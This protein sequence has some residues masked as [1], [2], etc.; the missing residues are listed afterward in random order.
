MPIV[1]HRPTAGRAPSDRGS[2][3]PREAS[4]ADRAI[5]CEGGTGRIRG[6]I[7]AVLVAALTL[8][9]PVAPA[10][11]DGA[12]WTPIAAAVNSGWQSVAYG[13]GVWVAVAKRSFG[14]PQ[15]MRST[16]GGLSWTAVAATEENEWRSVAYGNEVWV[17]VS[18]SGTN[19]VMR[20]TDNGVTWNNTGVTGVGAN[21]WFS[22]AYGA[23]VWVAVAQSTNQLM[24]STD[25]G[26]TWTTIAVA[27]S[28]DWR[29]VAYGNGTWVAIGSDVAGGVRQVMRSENAGLTWAGVDATE[30]SGW[31]SV[32]YGGGVWVA[33]A[34]STGTDRVMRSTDEGRNWARISVTQEAWQS[35]A[36]G[37]GVWVAVASGGTNRVMRSTDGGQTWTDVA[38]AEANTWF[39]VAYGNGAWIAV[40]QS[41]SGT[42]RVMRSVDPLPV[43]QPV[44]PSVSC[45]PEV[46]VAG[47]LVT[48]SVTGGDAGIDIL[49]RAA[50]GPVFAEVGVTLDDS[51]SGEFSF[52]VPAGA[53]GEEL[54]VELVEWIA[55][56]SLGVVGGPVP[57]SVPSG[58]GPA[59]VWPL[60]LVALVVFGLPGRG[61]R[62]EV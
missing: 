3:E 57:T 34:Q 38:A 1:P 41:G 2:S 56:V 30:A 52:T 27:D 20:S 51:G 4:D 10:A 47:G 44:P 15:L 50:H 49:W 26:V 18:S 62:T 39:S 5:S 29:S 40:A 45:S 11:A 12:S 58:G 46:L 61:M 35:V 37:N 59:P 60:V 17:A 55:P 19:R 43:S 32:A 22:V 36:Y 23:G 42:N 13:N 6:V 8:G 16:D 33:V 21:S 9:Q 7:V 54:T 53:V 31:T 48:C 14:A 24:R 28:D 25:D